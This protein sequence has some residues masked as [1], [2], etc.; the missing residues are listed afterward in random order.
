M[1][2]L[3]RNCQLEYIKYCVVLKFD[4]GSNQKLKKILVVDKKEEKER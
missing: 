2:P 1:I 4:L 3:C